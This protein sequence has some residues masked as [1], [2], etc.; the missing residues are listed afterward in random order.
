MPTPGLGVVFRARLGRLVGLTLVVV[1]L[2]L[3]HSYEHRPVLGRWSYPFFGLIVGVVGLWAVTLVASWRACRNGGRRAGRE[4]LRCASLDLAVLTWGMAYLLSTLD[5]PGSAARIL[6]LNL[7]GSATTTA[8]CLEWIALV[9]LLLAGGALAL[10]KLGVRWA[11]VGLSVAVLSVL[12][13]LGEGIAR[14]KAVLDPATQG[15]PTYSTE[16]WFRRHVRFN[17]IGFRD[18]EHALA[19]DP[20]TRRLLL[21]GDS[22]AFGVGIIDP[23]NRFGEQLAER[24]AR[25]TGE[26]WEA[27]NASR[28]DVHTLEETAILGRMLAFQPDVVV[29]LY[30]FNDIDYLR[31]MTPRTVLSEHPRTVA[32]RLHPVRML[33]RNSYAFQELYVR[34]RLLSL[35][36]RPDD[37]PQDDPYA[38]SALVGRA[39][40]DLSRFVTKAESAG[41]VVG[42]VPFDIGITGAPV[43]RRR[44]EG[45][46]HDATAARLRVWPVGRAFDGFRFSDLAVNAL[47]THPNELA[48]RLAAGEISH[49][50]MEALLDHESRKRLPALPS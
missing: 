11:N 4:R 49:Y 19:R 13:V 39:L 21:I 48:N 36:G 29:L 33:F 32:Q 20:G 40:V 17:Q 30:V 6:D 27:I 2:S 35:R 3:Y 23:N 46:V 42:I 37:T 8:V 44:Y 5:A 41:A 14:A 47:D 12:G 15:F 18:R 31:P 24:L 38:D 16:R 9:F 26:P 45:F 25:Q 10:G 22:F 1:S 7:M 50:L 34:V 28:P 43:L